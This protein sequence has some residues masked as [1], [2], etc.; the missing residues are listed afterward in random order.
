[1][2]PSSDEFILDQ[3]SSCEQKL[4]M[5]VEELSSRA[6]D[7]IEKEMEDQEICFNKSDFIPANNTRVAIPK[8]TSHSTLFGELLIKFVLLMTVFCYRE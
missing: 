1:M 4:V 8:A 3:L 6:L 2:D 7:T 5:L